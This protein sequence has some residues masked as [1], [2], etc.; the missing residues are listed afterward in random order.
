MTADLVVWLRAQ[1]DED[2]REAREWLDAQARTPEL[3]YTPRDSSHGEAVTVHVDGSKTFRTW[4]V[5]EYG[6]LGTTWAWQPPSGAV[7]VA[8]A[9]VAARVLVE[10]DTK[11]RVLDLY[12]EAA[13][14]YSRHPNEPAGEVSGLWQAIQ[15]MA[16][17]YRGRPGFLEKWAL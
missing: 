11:R 6:D 15:L 7:L 16:Q 13:E 5:D 1:L 14:W 12:E 17:P 8:G 4:L 9:S 3:L 2:E 10:V